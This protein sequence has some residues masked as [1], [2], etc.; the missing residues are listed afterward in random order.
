MSNYFYY[1]GFLYIADSIRRLWISFNPQGVDE[2]KVLNMNDGMDV[3]EAINTAQTYIQNNK[4]NIL[5]LVFG[6]IFFMWA[7]VGYVGNT[8]EKYWFL[9]DVIFIIVCN[10]F[11]VLVSIFFAINVIFKNEAKTYNDKKTPTLIIPFSKITAITE[12]II[13]SII[14]YQHFFINQL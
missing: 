14:L 13:V 7:I 1:I 5:P 8:P 2:K 12:L 11:L 9:A 10:T 6:V 4:S 3:G